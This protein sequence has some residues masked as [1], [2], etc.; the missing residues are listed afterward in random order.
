MPV[1]DKEKQREYNRRWYL[2]NAAT[3]KHKV[4]TR[5]K[6]LARQFMEYK[7]TKQ[8]LHCGEKD[9]VC[10]EFHHI[11]PRTKDIEPSQ[12]VHN[13]SWTLGR[14]I[15]Y[16]ETT[17]LVLCSNC[18]KKIHRDLRELERK[19]NESTARPPARKSRRRLLP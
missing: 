2:K 12:M 7:Q 5:R 6:E 19:K 18:H 15:E 4:R 3:H 16:L 14:I 13:K 8:C 17:C 11:D 10:L 1:R 9:H